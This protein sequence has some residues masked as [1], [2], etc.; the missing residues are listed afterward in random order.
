MDNQLEL[1]HLRYFHALGQELHYRKAAEK[2]FISQPGLS[3]QIQQLESI[4]DIKLFDRHNRKVELT[5]AGQYFQG[6]IEQL[7]DSLDTIITHAKMIDKGLGGRLRFGYLGSAMQSVIPEFLMK[8]RNQYAAIRFDLKEMENQEQIDLLQQEEI[9]IGFVRLDRA[10]QGLEM[11][12]IFQE[13]FSLVLPMDHP[14]TEENFD[15]LIQ[16]KEDSFILFDS[17]YSQSYYN[18][19]MQIFDHSGFTPIISHNTIHAVTIYR[20]VENNFGVSIV[21]SSLMQ[22]FDMNIRFIE[23]KDL[24]FN[25]TLQAIWKKDNPNP[26][27]NNV[28]GLL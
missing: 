12:A 7:F 15:S 24:D 4:I 26:I 25:T 5:K 22:G 17:S 19:V 2:L 8:I 18:K 20:L 3:R 9:D 16:F 10:P 21:P 1:R 13:N 27:L 14:I 11:Q 28:L 6:E 23:L